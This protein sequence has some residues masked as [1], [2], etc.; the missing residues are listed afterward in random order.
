MSTQKIRLNETDINVW[1]HDHWNIC[2]SQTYNEKLL[3][4]WVNGNGI[5]RVAYGS[6]ILYEG[7]QITHALAAW[8]A[9]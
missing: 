4:W 5:F 2:C 8:N 3:R 6:E 1:M 7:S 9:A